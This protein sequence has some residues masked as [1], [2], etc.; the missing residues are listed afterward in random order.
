MAIAFDATSKGDAASTSITVAHT[1]TGSNGLLVVTGKGNQNINISGATYNSVSMTQVHQISPGGVG[2]NGRV[3][4][5]Y[6]LN[7]STGANNVVV[8]SSGGTIEFHIE[9]VSYTGVKQSAQPDA[10]NTSSGVTT[11]QVTSVTIVATNSWALSC[12]WSFGANPS[13]STGINAVRN[14][15]SGNQFAVG[16]S[17]AGQSP[18][19]YSM[20]WT[21]AGLMTTLMASFAPVPA[22]G[23]TN[24]KSL[25]SNVA[26]NIKSFDS[27]LIANIKSIDSN[28]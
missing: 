28:T 6:L 2:T 24:L 4:M 10:S 16:D 3:F 9:N 18:G 25:D 27:N 20:T 15:D 12:Q 13:A 1:C 14:S 21:G 11:S 8:S 26:A 19:S 5:F 23:P 7:P 22:S 17:N